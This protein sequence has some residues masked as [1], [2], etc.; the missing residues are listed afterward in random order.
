ML[1]YHFKEQKNK[2]LL[3]MEIQNSARLDAAVSTGRFTTNRLA[4]HSRS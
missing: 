2:Y 3:E 1:E 4:K